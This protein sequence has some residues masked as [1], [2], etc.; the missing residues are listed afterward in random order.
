MLMASVNLVRE[1][2]AALRSNR[3]EI[4][5]FRDLQAPPGAPKGGSGRS[6]GGRST[7][8]RPA[9]VWPASRPALMDD[10]GIDETAGRDP[11]R[12]SGR[13]RSRE[14]MATY[15]CSDPHAFHG[16]ILKY[17]RRV[18][19]MT[20]EDRA[21]FLDLEAR[22]GDLG[23]LRIGDESIDRMNRALVDNIN[24]RVGPDDTLWCLGDWAFG[25]GADYRRNARW[26][27]DQIHCRDVRLVWGNH[28]DR[29]IR[30][31]FSA[32]HDQVRIRDGGAV[33]HP[34]PLPDDHLGRPAPGD[35]RRPQH[36]PL[37]PRPRP[38]PARARG[39]P[40]P[41]SPTP[42]RRSTSASTATITRSGRS[43]RSSKPSAPACSAW[44]P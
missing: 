23:P 11:P 4:A 28:D 26:F 5:F 27:R 19:F 43:P 15:Y 14:R 12:Q 20:P 30:D 44:R 6:P 40:A 21:A 24:A 9:D 3:L 7:H 18:A 31:L 29:S 2:H 22:G 42:G 38:L 36:P 37:R 10:T 41:A 39:L 34:E 1:A 16:N 17:C 25:R 33:D 8:P 13:E 32:T 35:R